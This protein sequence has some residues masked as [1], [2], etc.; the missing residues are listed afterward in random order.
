MTTETKERE[1]AEWGDWEEEDPHAQESGQCPLCGGAVAAGNTAAAVL[2]HVQSAHG[3][4]LAAF[5]RAQHLDDYQWIRLVNYLR[6]R[7]A[8]GAPAA[9]WAAL[10]ITADHA[11]FADDT[12]LL[13][14]LEND[15]LLETLFDGDS[16]DDDGKDGE[17]A[18]LREEVAALRAQNAALKAAAQDLIEQ[19]LVPGNPSDTPAP[20]AAA[21]AAAGETSDSSSSDDDEEDDDDKKEGGSTVEENDTDPYFGSYARMGIHEEMLRDA[22]RTGAYEEWARRAG[23]CGYMRGKTVL[24]VGAGTG[25]L[26]LFAARAGA[27]RV[28][29]VEASSTAQLARRVVAANGAADRVAVVA[30]RVE[31]AATD[32]AVRELTGG[33]GRVDVIVSEWMGY[34]LLY[35]NMLD[36]VVCARDRWLAPD[37]IV[38]PSH[39]LLYVA[40]LECADAYG[41]RRA[42]FEDRPYGVDL[43]AVQRPAFAEASIEVVDPAA[44]AAGPALLD[45]IDIR[46]VPARA[47]ADRTYRLAL[48]VTRAVEAVHCIC[49]Y[50]DCD[51]REPRDDTG[52]PPV[53]LSTAPDHPPT[54]WKQ[55]V[56]YLSEPLPACPAG[57]TIT[58]TLR[59]VMCSSGPHDLNCELELRSS[60]APNHTISETFHL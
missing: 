50:F 57:A 45:E 38:A 58:G 60:V 32:R 2:A 26:S 13:P 11:L 53:V 17:L 1:T 55:S 59:F 7:V 4:D 39:A 31:E 15:P 56:L 12:L 30:H 51:F 41:A 21:A 36:A 10:G 19:G 48:P 37:G 46:T 14:V 16:D 20:A 25:I 49:I 3:V 33:A 23:A 28:I 34:A 42:F 29:A 35:E 8:Q 9:D 27:A 18:R 52:V 54:H 5:R 47:F 22:V 44:V 24:D 43:R 40:G 6:R